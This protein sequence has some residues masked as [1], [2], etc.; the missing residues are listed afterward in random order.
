MKLSAAIIVRLWLG[1]V[2][3]CR[4]IGIAR[5]FYSTAGIWGRGRPSEHSKHAQGKAIRNPAPADAVIPDW[6][7]NRG[8]CSNRAIEVFPPTFVVTSLSSTVVFAPARRSNFWEYPSQRITVMRGGKQTVFTRTQ[9]ALELWPGKH[10]N[11]VGRSRQSGP[12]LDF[13]SGEIIEEFLKDLA[14][15]NVFIIGGG[16]IVL[17]DARIFLS[18]HIR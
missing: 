12:S 6:R 8:Q 7:L 9:F 13:A 15:C 5:Q 4:R 18:I 3:T 1:K 14:G 11:V 10:R 17:N 2:P 16:V